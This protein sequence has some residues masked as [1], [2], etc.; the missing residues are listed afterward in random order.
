MR[1]ESAGGCTDAP[2][3]SIHA[4]RVGC[5]KLQDVIYQGAD[6]FNPRTPC[7]VRLSPHRTR[8][9]LPAISIHAPRV[10]CDRR[11]QIEG[12]GRAD[13]NPRTP[14]GVRRVNVS[15]YEWH[16][17]FQSTH[18]VWGATGTC[19]A[20]PRRRPQ[21]Q[22]THPVW[23]ATT[24]LSFSSSFFWNFNPRTPCGVRLHQ[25]ACCRSFLPI[26]IHAPR[27]GCDAQIYW[28]KNRKPRFQSTHPVWGATKMG[29]RGG[30]SG[31]D[32]NPRTPCGVRLEGE[33]CLALQSHFNPRTPC[34]VRLDSVKRSG[35]SGV[36]SIHA[37]RV[38]C[39]SAAQSLRLKFG[40]FQSTHPVWGAT[41]GAGRSKSR[42]DNFN[43]RT[44][45]GVRRI[46]GDL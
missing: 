11:R 18:P 33:R 41:I 19:V 12:V 1:R 46:W 2:I 32:F 21:F 38:G 36:I 8:T 4:P 25:Q 7:G 31:G 43:P 40:Q 44:P 22:S 28:L 35:V 15:A 30:S 5:D 27:V 9:D 10:G 45:C 20:T 17:L 39:D 26:S 6:N 3:I 16:L 13:F 37:P 14:C 24:L 42:N 29:G 34:G 23:G